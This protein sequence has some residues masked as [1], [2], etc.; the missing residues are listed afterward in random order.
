M[1][2]SNQGDVEG[3]PSIETHQ[4]HIFMNFIIVQKVL[5]L[6]AQTH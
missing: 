4:K 2:L 5:L 6:S 3:Y 1:H